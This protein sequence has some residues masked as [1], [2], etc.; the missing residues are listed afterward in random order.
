MMV[1]RIIQSISNQPIAQPIAPK[2]F[3]HSHHL[4]CCCS[5]LLMFPLSHLVVRNPLGSLN[6]RP[7]K[8]VGPLHLITPRHPLPACRLTYAPPRPR[9]C[10]PPLIS[11]Y[12]TKWWYCTQEDMLMCRP[13]QAAS[14]RQ[15][16]CLSLQGMPS[17][18]SW[19]YPWSR[20]HRKFS[21]KA[22][23]VVAHSPRCC[24]DFDAAPQSHLG[25]SQLHPG[26]LTTVGLQLHTRKFA[27]RNLPQCQ[28]KQGHD[29]QDQHSA[30]FQHRILEL[31]V[32]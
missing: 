4:P 13:K 7:R 17:S 22:P 30:S 9:H 29:G 32:G 25:G 24:K 5:S 21:S 12:G 10:H 31:S 23:R 16:G 2:I 14:P 19:R 28:R 20:I 26:A 8:P 27:P 18:S 1:H 11:H 3:A 15:P 6:V